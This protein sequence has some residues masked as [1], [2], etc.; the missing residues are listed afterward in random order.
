MKT[1]L[2]AT[3]RESGMSVLQTGSAAT[4]SVRHVATP[5]LGA[6][7]LRGGG[8]ASQAVTER[9]VAEHARNLSEQFQ[10]LIGRGFGHQQHEQRRYRLAVG[11]VEWQ[12]PSQA[13][14][15]RDRVRKALEPGVR[16]GNALSVAAFA[17]W[18]SS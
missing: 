1:T 18:T 17:R 9:L 2:K 5:M 8:A 3:H 13:R 12:R 11:R 7:D 15:C 4:T 16:K 6:S 10:V 14:E